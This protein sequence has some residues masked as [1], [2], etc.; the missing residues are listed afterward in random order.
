M[1]LLPSFPR[2]Y[3]PDARS[4]IAHSFLCIRRSTVSNTYRTG[5]GKS[6]T[7]GNS[8]SHVT[9]T[10][11][12]INRPRTRH[13]L[14][15]CIIQVTRTL[16]VPEKDTQSLPQVVI[17]PKRRGAFVFRKTESWGSEYERTE[18]I[19]HAESGPR[20]FL[21]GLITERYP[22]DTGLVGRSTLWAT[23]SCYRGRAG[24][25]IERNL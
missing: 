14:N 24:I 19:T 20:A 23:D 22:G 7:R 17:K 2:R 3:A 10:T 21:I 11:P 18:E 16:F 15:L 1:G 6:E 8:E 25:A 9:G 5:L 4:R 12:P 13:E